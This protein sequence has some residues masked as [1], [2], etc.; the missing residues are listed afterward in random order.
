MFDI[1]VIDSSYTVKNMMSNA[2]LAWNMLITN[3]ILI[4]SNYDTSNMDVENKDKPLTSINSFLHLFKRNITILY[5]RKQI[6]IRKKDISLSNKEIKL[7]IKSL[8]VEINALYNKAITKEISFDIP[9]HNNKLKYNLQFGKLKSTTNSMINNTLTQELADEQQDISHGNIINNPYILISASIFD[10]RKNKKKIELYRQNFIQNIDTTNDRYK[11]FLH[12]Y[13][14][15]FWN[16][17][18]IENLSILKS[19]YTPFLNSRMS[20]PTITYLNF[21]YVH[22]FG[23]YL[24]NRNQIRLENQYNKFLCNFQNIFETDIKNIYV[25]D[26]SATGSKYDNKT[27]LYMKKYESYKNILANNLNLNNLD[28]MFDIIKDIPNEIDIINLSWLNTRSSTR[29]NIVTR[30]TTPALL[31]SITFCLL[32]QSK[33]GTATITHRHIDNEVSCQLLYM[34]SKYYKTIKIYLLQCQSKQHNTYTINVS[35][36]K[37]ITEKE[38]NELTKLCREVDSKIKSAGQHVTIFDMKLRED[39]KLTNEHSSNSIDLYLLNVLDNNIDKFRRRLKEINKER[40]QYSQNEYNLLKRIDY[41]FN[42]VKNNKQLIVNIEDL[43]FNKQLE[44]VLNWVDILSNNINIEYSGD[45][46]YHSLTKDLIK[47]TEQK[48]STMKT[49]I[50]TNKNRKTVSL[51]NFVHVPRTAGTAFTS[52]LFDNSQYKNNTRQNI[53]I[54]TLDKNY[55]RISKNV[56][57]K[58]I[59]Y[60]SETYKIAFIRNPFDRF[61]SSFAYLKEGAANNPIYAGGQKH[62]QKH[63]NKYK[64]PFDLLRAPLYER[65]WILNDIHFRPMNEFLLDENNNMVDYIGTSDTIQEDVDNICEIL[66]IKPFKIEQSNQSK[67]K[68][69]LVESDKKFLKEYYKDDF[70][71]YNKITNQNI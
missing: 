42:E 19:A 23:G 21:K 51:I 4:F 64:T 7:D 32:V 37:G 38:R 1:I 43:I 18:N 16:T 24:Q 57:S 6:I 55:V 56:H 47:R 14:I 13:S 35:G 65:D 34:L 41:I 2:I 48:L 50:Y 8:T 9:T 11:Y 39:L 28:N 58:A 70:V 54:D 52:A 68:Y 5:K 30:S 67:L 61:L 22:D 71:L 69:K 46:K 66:N 12:H 62:M 36:F 25:Y 29:Q 3:G 40:R 44:Y 26:I 53:L 27:N 63:M 15:N 17:S 59:D 33:D 49:Y 31:Y 20:S 60:P 45:I 10:H